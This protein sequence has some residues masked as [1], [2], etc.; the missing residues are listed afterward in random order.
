MAFV[1][2]RQSFDLSYLH[3]L[4]AIFKVNEVQYRIDD[5]TRQFDVSYA[6]NPAEKDYRLKIEQKDF[7][8]ADLLFEE[9]YAPLIAQTPADYYLFSFTKIELMDIFRKPDEWGDFDKLLAR[10]ILK[11]KG[12]QITEQT[13]EIL[14]ENRLKLLSTPERDDSLRV[15]FGYIFAFVFP[16][17]GMFFGW[18]LAKHKKNLPNGEV[19]YACSEKDR[20]KGKYI[21][22]ISLVVFAFFTFW[23]LLHVYAI[24]G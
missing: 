22:L 16:L 23:W 12:H 2:Y 14:Y 11:E 20:E 8:K 3:E 18:Y 7:V 17:L 19:V 10:K 6:N 21:M 15:L 4:A 5:H 13:E 9:Y 24:A 1:T